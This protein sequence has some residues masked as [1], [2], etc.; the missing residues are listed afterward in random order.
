MDSTLIRSPRR[1]NSLPYLGHIIL[2]R[3][4]WNS[5]ALSTYLVGRAPKSPGTGSSL[6]PRNH[7]YL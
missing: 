1:V 2:D 7:L 5:F 4:Q 6:A 3:G